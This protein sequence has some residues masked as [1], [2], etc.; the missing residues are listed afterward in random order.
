M[1]PQLLKFALPVGMGL[2][3]MAITISAIISTTFVGCQ[4]DTTCPSGQCAGDNGHC[5]S[6]SSGSYCTKSP[7]GNCSSAVSGV[8]CCTGSGGGGGGG[9]TPTGC[10]SSTPWLCG[11][12]CYST[13]PSGNHACIKCP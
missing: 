6:C 7:S 9:C 1:K 11:G 13:P 10:A 12:Y 8:S 3:L 2:L 4:K 5:Y